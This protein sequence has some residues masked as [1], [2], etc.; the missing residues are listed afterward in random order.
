[1]GVEEQ[2]FVHHVAP[3]ANVPMFLRLTRLLGG[4]CLHAHSDS[5]D[6]AGFLPIIGEFAA[7][8]T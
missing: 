7:K 3:L 6:E 2:T 8:L 5:Y 4:Q 1:M